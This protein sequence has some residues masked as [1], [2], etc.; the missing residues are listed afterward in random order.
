MFGARSLLGKTQ[1]HC[2]RS[3]D[4]CAAPTAFVQDHINKIKALAKAPPPAKSN[5]YSALWGD[6]KSKETHSTEIATLRDDAESVNS[7][8]RAGGCKAFDIDHELRTAGH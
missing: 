7:L 4:P 3:S 1:R 6:P 8:L 2:A 5:V